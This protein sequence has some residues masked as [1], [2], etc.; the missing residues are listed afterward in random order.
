MKCKFFSG[1]R[2][3][4]LTLKSNWLEEV[5]QRMENYPLD[6]QQRI[7][8]YLDLNYPAI[9]Y[10]AKSGKYCAVM[11]LAFTVAIAYNLD[12]SGNFEYRFCYESVPTLKREFLTWE[13]H[14][15]SLERLPSGWIACRGVPAEL[16]KSSFEKQFG[17]GYGK[18]MLDAHQSLMDSGRC[19]VPE[20]EVYKAMP[21]LDLEDAKHLWAYLKYSGQIES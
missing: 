5:A 15:F 14:D 16:L 2:K 19:W 4:G 12:P 8:G 9:L 1:V 10:N 18:E 7:T 13:H 6:V 3:I 11:Q 20:S 17:E 21:Q